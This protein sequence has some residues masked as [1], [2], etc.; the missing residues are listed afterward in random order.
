MR[1]KDKLQELS[2]GSGQINPS[3]AIHPGLIYDLTMSS[4]VR[5]MCKESHND[6][7]IGQLIGS[8]NFRCSNFKPA[9]GVDGLNY[10]SMHIQLPNAT[11]GISEVFHRTVTNV[12]RGNSVY[13]GNVTSPQGLSIS[14]F[15]TTLNFTRTHQRNSFKVVVKG[16][17]VNATSPLMI[18]SGSLEWS[19]ARH[20]VHSP[21][22]VFIGRYDSYMEK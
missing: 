5:F 8:K 9:Q 17:P 14:V 6:T 18:L 3:Q 13:T 1:I 16:D 15:P 21:I 20:V 19:D 4:Y 10:P 22:V 2:S 12:G 11:S 7:S